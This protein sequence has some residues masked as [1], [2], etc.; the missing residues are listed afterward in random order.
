MAFNDIID[1][2]LPQGSDDPAEADD[3]MRRIQGGFQELLD[4][5]H[6]FEKTG[7]E[8]SG[9]DSGEHRK[10]TLRTLSAAVVAALTATKA[11]LYRLVT[12][13]ELYWKDDDDN[14]LQL[15]DKGN[16]LPNATYLKATNEAD[17]G[18]VDLIKAGASDLATLSDGA[19][20]ASATASGDGDRTIADKGYVDAA[21]PYIKL[22]DTKAQN[23]DG[24]TFTSGS[25]QTRTLTE[26]TDTGSH[27]S[28]SSNQITLDAGTYECRIVCPATFVDRH[29]A[30]LYNVTGSA[31]ILTGTCEFS[32]GNTATTH[33]II[34]GR[35]TIAASKVLEVQHR[36]DSTQST[37]GFGE[38]SNFGSEVYTVAEFWKR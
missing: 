4:V 10:I 1:T 26:E 38:A 28:V 37:N 8:I 5:D 7:T 25:W 16:N 33:S 36:C 17:D 15:T 14:T 34:V 21:G 30:R 24:G 9:A 31:V 27:C 32:G 6:L 12:D 18:S 22:S 23:T 19:V 3:N 2:S 29:Q 35:F 11:Y 20:L 13:G